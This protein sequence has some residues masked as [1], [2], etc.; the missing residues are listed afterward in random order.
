MVQG[1]QYANVGRNR[2][3]IRK[4]PKGN[5]E[6]YDPAQPLSPGIPLMRRHGEF[7]FEID[8]RYIATPLEP[9]STPNL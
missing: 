6:A 3:A 9:L 2:E 5:F 1:V 7:R 4:T 8:K